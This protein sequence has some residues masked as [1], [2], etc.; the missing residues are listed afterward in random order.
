MQP[1]KSIKHWLVINKGERGMYLFLYESR[2]H[3]YKSLAWYGG[4]T[5]FFAIDLLTEACMSQNCFTSVHKK[6]KKL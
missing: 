6:N 3:K 5:D 1:K 2:S 4:L